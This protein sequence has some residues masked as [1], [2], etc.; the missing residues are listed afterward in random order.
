M[1]I[2]TMLAVMLLTSLCQSASAMAIKK[3]SIPTDQ[4]FLPK[5]FDSNDNTQ[6]VISGHLP[7]LCYHGISNKVEV[8]HDKREIKIQL[9]ADYTHPPSG[10]C[11]EVVMPFLEI[12]SLGNLHVG[13][14]DVK[15]NEGTPVA[16]NSPLPLQVFAPSSTSIDDLIYA[17]VDYIVK[18]PNDANMIKLVGENPMSCLVLKDIKIIS[19]DLDTYSILPIME[20]KSENCENVPSS[21]VYKVNIPSDLQAESILLHVRSMG[22][23]SVNTIIKRGN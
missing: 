12:V 18:D 6:I 21:F 23:K 7:N 17:N 2:R 13:K 15:I 16:L 9:M 19:N 10:F 14:Y 11:I 20:N 8:L 1:F 5:G 4:V 3:V 22:G